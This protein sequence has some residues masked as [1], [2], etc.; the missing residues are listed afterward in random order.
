MIKVGII[1][2]GKMGR[3]RAKAISNDG[4][5]VV[6]SVYDNNEAADFQGFKR[7]KSAEEIINDP[8]ID[9]VFICTPNYLNKS[10]T[11]SALHAG[12][13]VFCEKPPAFNAA[14][15]KEIREVEKISGKKLMYGFNHRHHS[16]IKHMKTLIDSGEYGNILWMRGRYGKSVGKDFFQ[17]WRA[18]KELAGGGI[19]LDQ[20]IHMLDLFLYLA[21]D[22][23]E[24][25]ATVSN[26]YWKLDIEDNVFAIF[27]NNEKGI[28]AQLHSTMTQ[29]RHLFSLEVFLEKGYLVLNG[30]KT[31]SGTYGD[32]VLS[33]AKNRTTAPAATWEDEERITYHTDMSWRS[34]IHHF[35]DAILND[36]SVDIGNS[37]DAL[38]LMK[39]IDKVYQKG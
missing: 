20:G 38:K 24:V 17:S 14:E 33:I 32:E 39:I 23:H 2:F 29:W 18:K 1:G 13:H 8:A 11:I 27:K 3:I 36:T 37:L 7:T 22:F 15:I 4:K 34:E 9:A 31:S 10:L 35:F 19:L 21:G 25:Q 12:K 16:S 26:L 6:V 5:G 28:V 30:L